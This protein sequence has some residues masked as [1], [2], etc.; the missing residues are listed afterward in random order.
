MEYLLDV[1]QGKY[2]NHIAPFLWIHGEDASVIRQEILQIYECGIR[3]LCVEARPHNDFNGPGW[4]RDL[5]IIQG[6]CKELGMKMWILDDSH[7]PT[8]YA[9]GEVAKN[10]PQLCKKYLCSKLLDFCGPMKDVGAI[11]KYALRDETDEII[12]VLLNRKISFETIDPASAIDLTDK[13]EWIPDGSVENQE[14]DTLEK[15]IDKRC[16]YPVVNFDLPEGAW[17]LTVLTV[18][19]KGGE[20]KT[21][22][23]LNPIDPAATQILLDTVYQ[24][25]YDHFSEEFGKTIL[26]F[27]SDEPR[28]GNLHG[29]ENASIGRNVDMNLPWRDDLLEILSERLRGTVL[30]GQEIRKLLPLLF[31]QSDQEEAHV[32]Q[33]VYMDLISQMYSENFDG[34]IAAWCEAHHCQ[35]IGHTIEDNNAMARLGYGAGHFF[36]SMAHQDMAGIDVVIQQ[37]TPG[38]DQGMF[39]GMHRPG[40]DGEFFHYVLA[41]AGSSLAEMNPKMQGRSMCEL[42]GAYGW[43]EG[44]RL[45]KWLADHMLVRGVNYFV[46][47]AFDPAPF[48]DR[49]CP[50]HFFAQGHNPQYREFGVLIDYMNRMAEILSGGSH[51]VPVA[52]LFHAEAEWSGKYMLTQKPAAELARHCIDYSIVPVEY[53]GDGEIQNGKLVIRGQEFQ[54]LVIPYAE[55]LPARLLYMAEQYVRNGGKVYFI[56]GFPQRVCEGS[57]ILE[58]VGETVALQELADQIISDGI[59]ELTLEEPAP[60]LRY[61]HTYKEGIHIY[62]F[63]NEGLTDISVRVNGAVKGNAYVYDAFSNS[64]TEE[65]DPFDLKLQ[66]CMSKCVIVTETGKT[67]QPYLKKAVIRKEIKE[68]IALEHPEIRLAD[69]EERCENYGEPINLVQFKPINTLTGLETFAGRI[70][71][72]MSFCLTEEQAASDGT[73]SLNGVREGAVVTV[74]DVE[75]GKRIC[76][77]YVFDVSNAL[78]AGE[79]QVVVEVNT[80]LGRRY[81]D[82]LS[83]YLPMEPLGITEGVS[84]KLY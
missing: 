72:Q 76:A 49:D 20:K 69:A 37:L 77:P 68:E 35:H 63:T 15:T 12:G 65:V 9:N 64:L 6:I 80:T 27:F 1:L 22:G 70:C 39:K 55:A 50:P 17:T 34:V 16:R 4:F 29:A 18:S 11:L 24:P 74:N 43:A 84:L 46:P 66:P 62:F 19:Y 38:M 2:K 58:T 23:Y 13:I 67:L 41:K 36:R 73:L 8:G 56:D 26:G 33:Y 57:K 75:C 52:L 82:F 30:E 32:L 21:E 3:A 14:I 71:Y 40:W 47:H 25:I 79:N 5:G 60:Y 10:H 31:L 7:F 83:Q 53:I 78:K 28:F 45:C 42:F 44:N 51:V 59:A 81:K 48:P 61:Y 54:T